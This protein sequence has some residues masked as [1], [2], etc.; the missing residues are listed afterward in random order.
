MAYLPL[1][2]LQKGKTTKFKLVMAAA[3]RATEL[4]QGSKPLVKSTSKKNTT[5]ALEEMI[6]GKVGFDIIDSVGDPGNKSAKK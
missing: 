2:D 3:Q 6:A 1:E 5:V 4:A